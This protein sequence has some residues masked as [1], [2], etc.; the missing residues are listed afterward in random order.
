MEHVYN[1]VNLSMV[2]LK[3]V[4]IILLLLGIG[5]LFKVR[6]AFHPQWKNVIGLGCVF[7]LLNAGLVITLGE[8]AFFATPVMLIIC[9]VLFSFNKLPLYKIKH[10]FGLLIAFV[11]SSVTFFIGIAGTFF[12]LAVEGKL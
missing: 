3:S 7:G 4:G 8:M 1:E 11:F 12:H 2:L 5:Y 6:P 10:L 9:I